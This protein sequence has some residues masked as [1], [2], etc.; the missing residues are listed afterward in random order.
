VVAQKSLTFAL[1]GNQN[2]GKTTLFNR[3]TGSQLQVSNFPGV[4]VEKKS[5]PLRDYPDSVV[6]DLPGIYSLSPYS[7]EEIISRN[8]LL[9]EKPDCIL[10]IVD[11]TSL[12]RGLYLTLQLIELD[13]PM[14]LALNMIDE[15]PSLGRQVDVALLSE[16]LGIPVVAISASQNEG[17]SEYMRVSM[18][19]ASRHEKPLKPDLCSGPVH[20]AVHAIAVMIEDH[21]ERA[22]VTPRFAA[23]KLIEGDRLF[24]P[25]LGLNENE[26][27][28]V[29]HI[30]VEMEREI[31]TDRLA[32]LAD[33]RYG[34][35]AEIESKVLRS[36][37]ASYEEVP[38]ATLTLD[39]ILL[40]RWLGIPIFLA[41]MGAVS[42]ISFG[43]AG[44][45]LNDF[46]AGLISSLG[47]LTGE[48]MDHAG[49]NPLIKSLVV[50]GIFSGVGSVVSFLPMI[51]LLFF[52]LSLLEVTGYMAR[53]AFM[54]DRM[55]RQ[56]GLSGASM[57]PLLL[58]FGCSVPAVMA[59]RTLPSRR[60]RLLTV[61]LVPFMSCSAKVPVYGLIAAAVFPRHV[62]LVMLCL[63]ALG[64]LLSVITAFF[65][66]HTFLRGEA[67]PFLLELP[68]YRFPTIRTLAR[69]VWRHAKEFLVRAFTIILLVTLV[70]W[71]LETYD[72]QFFPASSPDASMLS[73]IAQRIATLF[74][75]LGF[76]RWE[77]VG[78]LLAGFSAK[79]T[80]ISTLTVAMSG[81]GTT[82][83]E[84]LRQIMTTPA[85]LSFLV[86][87][88]LYTPCA[89]AVTV[90]RRELNIRGGFF[91]IILCQT[92]L[93][94]IAA[95]F[96][97]R[98]SLLFE[99]SVP[100]FIV[101]LI[102]TAALL[103]ITIISV[104]RHDKRKSSL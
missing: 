33:M 22:G 57:V 70:I 66:R 52:L 82:L 47:R 64:M 19:A 29:E 11:A 45:F 93:A 28:A 21:A 31:G 36:K 44:Q 51:L 3:L 24:T 76:D 26:L 14:T 27:E 94:W 91:L 78:A 61:L 41:V 38:S 69:L 71:F 56:I 2:S 102:A 18:E 90:M 100:L 77:P 97:Y 88:S 25:E 84:A 53:V 92:L 49:L 95:F 59:T 73:V 8:Y 10:N 39:R 7:A 23:T 63:Y 32:A 86:F 48:S 9:K 60:D 35:I 67:S 96:V 40:H 68:P 16:E 54:L 37:Y 34:F 4:T 81:M 65:L 104:R 80:I 98:L 15:M 1:M 58:G 101:S 46:L 85:A 55:M 72:F 42:W 12:E 20:R 43:P 5:G 74:R 50:D 6:V 79:E 75:P 13:I 62:A 30:V 83:S 87:V 103:T 89:A 99:R 17:V